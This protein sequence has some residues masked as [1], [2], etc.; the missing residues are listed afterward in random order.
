LVDVVKMMQG[1][2]A[3]S[4]PVPVSAPVKA[5]QPIS[6][7]VRG[8]SEIVASPEQSTPVDD[9]AAK[10]VSLAPRESWAN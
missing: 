4:E 8:T 1:D 6:T 10:R 9:K 5:A 3:P 2:T 7:F